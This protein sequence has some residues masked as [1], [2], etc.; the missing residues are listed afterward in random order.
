MSRKWETI[1]PYEDRATQWKTSR[2]RLTGVRTKENAE[3]TD[4]GILWLACTKSGDTVTATLYKDE[5]RASSVASGTADVSGCDNSGANA[6]Q[7]T[8]TA[9]DSSGLSGT[10][11]IHQ[12]LA[13]GNCPILVSLATDEDLDGL[14]DGIED[15]PGYSASEGCAEF[16]RIACDDVIGKVT[17][18]YRKFL[19]GHGA[20]AAWF[21]TD[22]TRRYPDLRMIANPAQLRQ[23]TAFRALAIAIGRSHDMA[24]D[25]VYS[26]QRDYFDSNYEAAMQSLVLAVKGGNADDPSIDGT[27]T[28]VQ[29]IRV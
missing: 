1:I 26:E 15:L 21:I 27:S 12:Y 8:L 19:G 29:Q 13:D 24:Q 25:T 17:A 2:W 3:N 11:W 7:V 16:I 9:T 28:L 22:A 20:D 6:V 23:A 14:W 18:I 5:P 4:S 10:F